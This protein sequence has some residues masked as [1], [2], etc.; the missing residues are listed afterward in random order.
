MRC[1]NAYGLEMGL[2]EEEFS[3]ELD[4][5]IALS[6]QEAFDR[7]LPKS[8]GNRAKTSQNEGDDLVIVGESNAEDVTSRA[9]TRRSHSY[10]WE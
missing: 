4:R 8:E 6:L 10:W 3:E 5:A 9:F 1:R 2:P 7:E